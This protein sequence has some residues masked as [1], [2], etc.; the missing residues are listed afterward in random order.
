MFLLRLK[1]ECMINFDFSRNRLAA[2]AAVQARTSA[3]TSSHLPEAE[4]MSAFHRELTET[5]VDMMA[6]YTFSTFSCQPKR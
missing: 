1:F 2:Q 4:D 5:C 6:T 3:V